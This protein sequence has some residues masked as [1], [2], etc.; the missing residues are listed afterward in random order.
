MPTNLEVPNIIRQQIGNR[1]FVMMGAK[2]LCG[3]ETSLTFDVR[4]S[5]LANHVKVTLDPS[6]TY[7]VKVMKI[8]GNKLEAI[9][10]GA[11][12]VIVKVTGERD[13]VYADMLKPVLETLTGLYL[14]L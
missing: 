1:A 12:G 2:N 14:S 5:K 6:D 3:D 13:M 7:T 9:L 4:G 8:R 11:P 10:A